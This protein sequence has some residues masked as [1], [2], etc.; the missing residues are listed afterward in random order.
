[1]SKMIIENRSHL[2]DA[3]CLDLVKYTI[4]KGRIS[5]NEKQYCYASVFTYGESS[6]SLYTD[7]NKKSDRFVIEDTH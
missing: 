5:N 3:E 7:L 1:M 2:S 4:N 6:V